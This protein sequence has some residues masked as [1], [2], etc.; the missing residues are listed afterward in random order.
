MVASNFKKT[1]IFNK[2]VRDIKD[3][4]IQG[5]RSIAKAALIAYSLIP[6]K[7]SRNKLISLRPTEPMLHNVLNKIETHSYKEILKHFDDSQEKINKFVLSLIK[8]N[9]VVFTHCHSTNVVQSLISAKKKGKNFEVYNTET[10]PLLQGRKTAKELEKNKIRVTQ[11]VDSALDVALGGEQGS[12]KVDK[13]F[14]G[15]D[16]LLK[17]GIVNKIGSEV[18][19]RIAKEEKIPVYI[20]AD[21]WKFTKKPIPY[22]QRSL[23]EVWDKAPKNIKIKNPAFEFLDKKYITK[24]ISELGILSYDEF[25]RRMTK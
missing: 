17:K 5:A 8:S 12:K 21:S 3:V 19:A 22:E 9:D 23:N 11:F 10:R 18:V 15:A 4:K 24:I 20:V 14:L 2:I 25:V 6:T 7:Y 13:V 16:A 1:R